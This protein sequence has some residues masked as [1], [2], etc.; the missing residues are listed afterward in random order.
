MVS[1]SQRRERDR[2]M[3]LNPTL[4]VAL[5]MDDWDRIVRVLEDSNRYSDILWSM[6]QQ[7]ARQRQRKAGILAEYAKRAASRPLDD[8]DRI[9][10]G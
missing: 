10:D 9:C 4:F 1:P 8:S 6:R 5:G 7:L 3:P 2:T